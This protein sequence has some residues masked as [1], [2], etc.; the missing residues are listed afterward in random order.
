MY[1]GNIKLTKETESHLIPRFIIV[2]SAILLTILTIISI[3]SLTA[4]TQK[5]FLY[6]EI[7]IQKGQTLWNIA[8]SEFGTQNDIRKYVY[9]IKQINNL[10]D[11]NIK[12]GQII[13]VPI[14][15]EV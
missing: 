12:P 9:K 11:A 3:W 6:K 1:K 8:E 10:K 7:E 14:E 2:I 13:R 5:D 15:R 4:D